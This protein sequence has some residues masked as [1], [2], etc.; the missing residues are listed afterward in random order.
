MFNVPRFATFVI[1]F[2]FSPH[3]REG[4]VGSQCLFFWQMVGQVIDVESQG[5]C[6]FCFH[7]KVK[8][9]SKCLHQ[10]WVLKSLSLRML[11]CSLVKPDDSVALT[12]SET[13]VSG[14][15][16]KAAQIARKKRTCIGYETHENGKN[17]TKQRGTSP[18]REASTVS[19]MQLEG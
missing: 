8:S 6:F 4:S 17:G 19:K 1:P 3:G 2:F 10:D 14:C 5:D 13:F 11:C 9:L 18:L 16:I 7:W 15:C 12:R